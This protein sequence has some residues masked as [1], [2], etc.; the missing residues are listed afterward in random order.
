MATASTTPNA[1]QHLL[2]ELLLFLDPVV[3]AARDPDEALALIRPTGWTPEALLGTAGAA[4]LSVITTTAGAVTAIQQAVET[5]PESLADLEQALTQV[6][7]VVDSLQALPDA[8]GTGRPPE[9]DDL[10]ADLIDV[11]T[12]MYLQRRGPGVIPILRALTLI[13]DEPVTQVVTTNG[14]ARPAGTRERLDLARIG[15]L[16]T[17]PVGHLKGHYVPDGLKDAEATD[18]A[19]DRLLPALAG[20]LSGLGADT[21]Y[22]RG[23]SFR[24][25]TPAEEAIFRRTLTVGWRSGV[26]DEDLSA[27]TELGLTMR[28][29]GADEQGPGLL[30]APFGQAVLS[31]ALAEEWG[32][33]IGTRVTVQAALITSDG[34]QMPASAAGPAQ[35]GID[36]LI[37]KLAA[38]DAPAVRV[39][40]VDGTRLEIGRLR[41]AMTS[42]FD[43]QRQRIGFLLEAVSGALVVAAGDGDGFLQ[44]ILPPEGLRTEIDLALGW[45]TDKGL[46]FR[47]GAGLE[48][49]LPVNRSIAGVLTIDSV[50]LGLR[51]DAQGLRAHTA[52][53]VSL[54]LGPVAVSVEGLGV[55]A[56]MTFPE[57]GGNIG[58][59]ELHL[60]FKPPTG[61]GLAIDAGV[62]VGGGY[63]Y[64]DPDKEQ[65]A[66]AVHLELA[67]TL[68][69][70]AFG[71]LTTRMPDGSPGFSL[72]VL[73]AA[74]FSPPIQLG[75]GF[76]LSGIGGLVGVNR[77]I[78]IDTLRTGLRTG[79]L[80]SVLFPT[81]PIRNAP[82]II[83]DL[84][85]IFPPAPGR[86]LVGPMVQLGWGTPTL[87]SIEL[88]IV[89]ELP[90]PIRL[91]LLG[92]LKVVLPE[93]K[94][95]IVRLQLDAVGLIDF[96]SGDVSLDA[97]LFDS[98]I[99]AFTVTGEMALRA[100]FGNRPDMVL[101]IGGF[102]PR[103]Q[104][105]A[106]FPALE[107]VAINLA[108][109]DNP[110]LRLEA[111][112]AL[113][114][115]TV[116]FG[117]LLDL[118]AKAGP[119]SIAGMLGLDVLIQLAPFGFVADLGASLA[120]KYNNKSVMSIGLKMTLTGPTPWHAWGKAHY[121]VLFFS[122]D[123]DF[124][125]RIG[126]AQKPALP[127]PVDLRPL[128]VAALRDVANW[129]TELPR[130]EHPLVSLRDQFGGPELLVHPLAD[131]RVTQRIAPFAREISRY[132]TATPA[133]YRVF[134][135][136][137]VGTDGKVR[138]T[139]AEGVLEVSEHFAP[140][141]FRR[142]SDDEKLTA[143]AFE[144]MQAGIRFATTGYFCG[145]AI[146]EP[147]ITY[148][149]ETIHRSHVAPTA[150]VVS[151]AAMEPV[152][153][154]AT[155]GLELAS[156]EE[157]AFMTAIV[158]SFAEPS[159]VRGDDVALTAEFV[160]RV[161]SVGA[162]AT[163][164]LAQSGIGRPEAA[165]EPAVALRAPRFAV[166]TGRGLD[167]RIES[168]PT[169][170]T[171]PVPG[172][173]VTASPGYTTAI[174][175]L[176]TRI[177]D[178]PGVRGKLHVVPVYEGVLG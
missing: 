178:S 92:R 162:A 130:G 133:P 21:V 16:L 51:A 95:P 172:L 4:V 161:A 74:T 101:A 8:F 177:E 35:I 134:S 150:A 15:D 158:P 116:Q 77:T 94:A 73:I 80:G 97:V 11:L 176:Q 174:E 135:L 65:Y 146:V 18:L 38:E 24:Q 39:G 76:T 144:R 113:T 86:F 145:P 120:L 48:A 23:D 166:V 171:K 104:P 160:D 173:E 88:G 143:P 58:F 37:E 111:Y 54:Q 105:P 85:V 121:E 59:A 82:Q 17:D 141:Q 28:L 41:L 87:L 89:L 53:A 45:S 63:L 31:L 108:T 14:L 170:D 44:Q 2:E 147:E 155:D 167:A 64:F 26:E 1:Q 169:P 13:H 117:A 34:V 124:D 67:E 109:G 43:L 115:N 42:D 159:T 3:R 22:G 149:R 78:A 175:E 131:L 93:P 138:T 83:S 137:V 61:A 129:S 157:D 57:G 142:M 70:T 79:S 10:P 106:G 29:V 25:A 36:A 5:P 153:A 136:G 118:F 123:I 112:F 140:A 96:G 132:G 165:I 148:A 75:Y 46:S 30:L 27:Q 126:P 50:S 139:A 84:S 154:A 156:V 20:L 32:L 71:L 100:N 33:A 110:R 19:A 164:P 60:Q 99:A 68:S 114:T 56:M 66:G 127:P 81:D 72:L 152:F 98:K 90:A 69:L 62:V 125:V 40:S 119:F 163:S 52:T 49:T 55:Q 9:L 168:I 6:A 12:L 91:L 103:F 47:G 151:R 107:R 122:G 7:G 128:L 102:N